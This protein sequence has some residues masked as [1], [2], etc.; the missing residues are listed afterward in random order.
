MHNA[1]L[2]HHRLPDG[3]GHFDWMI[4]AVGRPGLVTFR[5]EHRI[6]EA[7]GEFV[8]ERLA[9]HRETYLTYQ[10]QVSG[11]RGDV[12]RVAVGELVL[13]R[14]DAEGLICRGRLGAFVGE[15]VGKRIG[16][17]RWEFVAREVAGAGE[18]GS[19]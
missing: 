4:R 6:D 14:D 10:G 3:S 19:L 1:V 12:T 5:V 8:A 9:D 7:G 11:G 13:E 15:F 18:I 2:L 17:G 16:E